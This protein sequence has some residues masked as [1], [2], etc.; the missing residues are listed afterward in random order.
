LQICGAACHRVKAL[1]SE[2]AP[3]AKAFID[4]L[5]STF[6]KTPLVIEFEAQPPGWALNVYEYLS[7]TRGVYFLCCSPTMANL[8]VG[9]PMGGRAAQKEQMANNLGRLIR[10]ARLSANRVLHTNFVDLRISGELTPRA[11][12]DSFMM[13][14]IEGEL[15]TACIVIDPKTLKV[16]VTGKMRGRTDDIFASALHG[17]NCDTCL[18]NRHIWGLMLR[19]SFMRGM[20]NMP[21]P[22]VPGSL[23]EQAIFGNA[24][25]AHAFL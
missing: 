5:L 1:N 20:V 24:P 7:K 15:K 2:L 22:V 6:P 23:V 4:S 17:G 12:K 10:S 9:I 3:L 21:E 16:T 25:A 11:N 14:K 19:E 18:H 8:G 13:A